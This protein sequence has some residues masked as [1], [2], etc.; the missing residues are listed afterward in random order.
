VISYLHGE[1]LFQ[2]RTHRRLKH[3]F[4]S[5]D[6]RSTVS[7]RGSGIRRR[8]ECARLSRQRRPK[9]HN[10]IRT[11]LQP[12]RPRVHWSQSTRGHGPRKTTAA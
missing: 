1:V 4:L 3:Q 8:R 2:L 11:K 9:E 5:S 12:E 6:A 7:L 10:C